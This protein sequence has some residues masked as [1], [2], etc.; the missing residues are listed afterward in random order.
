MSAN[1]PTSDADIPVG[2]SYAILYCES[3]H[4]P[5]DERSRTNPGHG[6]PARNEQVWKI[7]IFTHKSEWEQEIKTKK[8]RAFNSTP[9]IPVILNQPKL[10][11]EINIRIEEGED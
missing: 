9:W 8:C 2:I 1:W 10:T 11:T 4:I 5:G 3:I 6:Y 7:Q